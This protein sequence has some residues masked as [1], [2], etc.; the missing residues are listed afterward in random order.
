MCVSDAGTSKGMTNDGNPLPEPR[1]DRP[2]QRV[3]LASYDDRYRAGVLALFHSVPFKSRIWEWQFERNPFDK[4]FQ[5]V[6]VTDTRDRV[7]GFNGVMPIDVTDHGEPLDAI[8]SCDFYVDANHRGAG[9]GSLLKQGLSDRAAIIL[10]LGVSNKASQVLSH[11]GWQAGGSVANYKRIRRRWPLRNLAILLV[12]LKNL[13]VGWRRMKMSLRHTNLVINAQGELPGEQEVDQLW[14]GIYGDY[15]KIVAR[16][17]RYLNWKYQQHP[18][19]RYGFVVVRENGVLKAIAVVRFANGTLRVVDYC[20][21]ARNQGLKD[22]LAAFCQ[23]HWKH[24][25]HFSVTTSDSELGRSFLASGY[26]RSHTQ[27]KFFVRTRPGMEK[28]DVEGWFLM[29]G[30]SDGELLLAARQFQE[31]T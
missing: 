14:R 10:A 25:S 27:P 19:A 24:G 1:Q 4:P 11:I 18:L 5:P 15:G 28:S 7:V 16:N 31:G 2:G 13:V 6:I 8:W 22:Q 3:Q 21:P 26:Y 29:G 12:Q 20:G 30:D 23:T 9:I 17:Y